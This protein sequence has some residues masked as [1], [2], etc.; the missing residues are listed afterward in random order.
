[1]CYPLLLSS[2]AEELETIWVSRVIKNDLQLTFPLLCHTSSLRISFRWCAQ[3]LNQF[4]SR[5]SFCALWMTFLPRH[6]AEGNQLLPVHQWQ[7]ACLWH[8]QGCQEESPLFN[9]TFCRFFFATSTW[10]AGCVF[11][12]FN[13]STGKSSLKNILHCR[14][15]DYLAKRRV[16]GSLQGADVGG[17]KHSVKLTKRY[18]TF[19][20]RMPRMQ[21]VTVWGVPAT[22]MK[23]PPTP[24]VQVYNEKVRDLLVPMNSSLAALCTLSSWYT[25]VW[26]IP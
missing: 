25:W 26:N 13:E 9:T 14:K 22:M 19:W 3:R 23:A 1:M 2:L 18:G 15:D 21:G 20:G 24:R 6:F 12:V 4:R 11:E 16:G 10:T 7:S 8:L 17:T 5:A